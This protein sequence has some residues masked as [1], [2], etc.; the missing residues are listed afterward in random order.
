MNQTA[1]RLRCT[2]KNLRNFCHF[3][4]AEQI[5]HMINGIDAFGWTPYA[6]A[7]TTKRHGAQVFEYRTYT[8][9]TAGATVGANPNPSQ[10]QIQVIVDYN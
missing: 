4:F 8:A 3:G 10:G 6:K 7:N 2:D 5:K 9:V 1:Q